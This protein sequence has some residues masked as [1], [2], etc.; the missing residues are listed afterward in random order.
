MTMPQERPS[1]VGF[2]SPLY[3]VNA[4]V[5]THGMDTRVSVLTTRVKDATLE[6][7]PELLKDPEGVDRLRRTVRYKYPQGRLI[8]STNTVILYDGQMPYGDGFDLIRV[9]LQPPI[10]RFWPEKSLVGELLELQRASDKLESLVV[11]NALRMRS[12]EHTSE[13]QSQSNLVCRLL[14]E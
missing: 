3:P 13:L 10:H 11:E 12:E 2:L 8:Q 14:L 5:P 4:P 7:V 1:G 9:L 6:V